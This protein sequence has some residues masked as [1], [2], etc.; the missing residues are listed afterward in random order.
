MTVV[1]HDNDTCILVDVPYL[2]TYMFHDSPRLIH[3]NQIPQWNVH[4]RHQI[5]HLGL[6]GT[7]Q[8]EVVVTQKHF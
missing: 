6:V 5:D 1:Q 4:L 8:V 2:I 3:T 7:K